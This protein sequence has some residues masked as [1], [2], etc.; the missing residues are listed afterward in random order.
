MKSPSTPDELSVIVNSMLTRKKQQRGETPTPVT[1]K[2][3]TYKA[4]EISTK[5]LFSDDLLLQ[6]EIM[7][8]RKELDNKQRI[9]ETLLQQV[10]ENVTPIHQVEN[11]TF[12]NFIN[13]VVN[14]K[15]SKYQSSKSPSKLINDNTME[16]SSLTKEKINIQLNDVRKESRKRFYESKEKKTKNAFPLKR[17]T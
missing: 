2:S 10:S 8:L 17:N 5:H 3:S 12:N 9:T 6:E 14:I 11:T 15:S 1:P 16:K 7:F 13:K 4:K